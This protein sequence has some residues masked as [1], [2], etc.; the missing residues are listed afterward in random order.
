MVFP[1]PVIAIKLYICITAL[2]V[3]MFWFVILALKI[4]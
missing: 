4:T 1:T 2:F 3:Q